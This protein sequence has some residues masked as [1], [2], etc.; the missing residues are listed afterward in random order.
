MKELQLLNR[1][2]SD[3]KDIDGIIPYGVGLGASHSLKRIMKDFNVPFLVDIDESKWNRKFLGLDII[4]PE[5]MLRLRNQRKII[6]TIAPR[7]YEEIKKQFTAYGLA[8]YKDFCHI[9]EFA[10]EWYYK[11]RRE[12]CIFT[13]DVAITTECTLLCGHC[14]MFTPYYRKRTS[15]SFSDMKNN[16]DLLFGRVDFVFVLR[17]LGGEPLLNRDLERIVEYL[18]QCHGAKFGT[19]TITTNGTMIPDEE[20]LTVCKRYDV[21]FEISN[22]KGATKDRNQ[23]GLLTAVLREKGISYTRRDNLVWRDFHFPAKRFLVE[24]SS[25]RRHMMECDPGWRGLNDGKFYFCN[26]A[27]SAEKAGLF[28]LEKADYIDLVELREHAEEDRMKLLK[29]SLGV[30]ENG[31]MSFCRVCA[32][33]GP[34]NG[35]HVVAGE[36]IE[37]PG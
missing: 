13:I 17:I 23:T 29:Y 2:T 21:V 22:Y 31:Y 20:L 36:Q 19:V 4:G 3:W 1:L 11:Y 14:N 12:C 32:G 26:C 6:V 34:D 9:R 28:A 18:H 37:Y 25:A 16:F 7:R 5:A 27:W 33:C 8:E 15:C 24:E 10:V 30:M 35:S